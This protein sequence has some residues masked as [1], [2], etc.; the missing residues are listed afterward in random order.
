MLY[1]IDGDSYS[2]FSQAQY[3]TARWNPIRFFYPGKKL[4]VHI[5][6]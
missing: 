1:N 2:L 4:T 3:C 6:T 5:V